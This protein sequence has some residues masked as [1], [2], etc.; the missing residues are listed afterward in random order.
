MS[1]WSNKLAS[2]PGNSG[3]SL[4][5]LRARCQAGDAEAI[6]EMQILKQYFSS[7]TPRELALVMDQIKFYNEKKRRKPASG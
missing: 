6:K 2:R 3:V 1:D 7:L 5:E 4:R